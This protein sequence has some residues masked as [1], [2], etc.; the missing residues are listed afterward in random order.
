MDMFSRWIIGVS[1]VLAATAVIAGASVWRKQGVI[2]RDVTTNTIN[3][4]QN[5]LLIKQLNNALEEALETQEDALAEIVAMFKHIE[6][7]MKE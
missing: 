7:H 1:S 3:I 6:K 5:T 2:E 4:A